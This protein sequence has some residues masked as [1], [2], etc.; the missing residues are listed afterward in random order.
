MDVKCTRPTST[1][2]TGRDALQ[3]KPHGEYT[4]DSIWRER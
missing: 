1:S 2:C 3:E 4:A